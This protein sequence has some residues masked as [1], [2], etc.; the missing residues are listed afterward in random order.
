MDQ[1]ILRFPEQAD[2]SPEYQPYYQKS[3]AVVIGIDV[4]SGRHARLANA[5]NDAR[6]ITVLLRNYGFDP[7]VTFY[8]TGATRAAIMTYLDN[9]L[10]KQVG[11]DDRVV[12][13]FAGHGTTQTALD[14]RQ[15]GYLVPYDSHR[16]D[17]YIDL[18]EV[19]QLCSRLRAKHILLLLDCC[20]S[21]VAALAS[22]TPV[23]NPLAQETL[24][25]ETLSTDEFLRTAT[26]GRAWQ[27][28]TA[29]AA[30]EMVDDSSGQAGRST[31]TA[32]LIMGL[33]GAADYNRDG[34]ITA[35]DLAAYVRWQMAHANTQRGLTQTPFFAYLA[36]DTGGDF[37]FELSQKRTAIN[38][39]PP[40]GSATKTGGAPPLLISLLLLGTLVAFLFGFVALIFMYVP[41]RVEPLNPQSALTTPEMAL[42]TGITLLVVAAALGGTAYLLQRGL[43]GQRAWQ[44][45][46]VRQYKR[47]LQPLLTG[48]RR[49]RVDEQHRRYAQWL[50]QQS[51][52]RLT[53]KRHKAELLFYLYQQQLIVNQAVI[54]LRE[55]DLSGLDL[56]KRNLRAIDLAGTNLQKTNFSHATLVEANLRTANLTE[57]DLWSA[58]LRDAA[59][60][61]AILDRAN[62]TAATL[63]ARQLLTVKSQRQTIGIDGSLAA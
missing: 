54:S 26:R 36:D 42:I 19:R 3:W 41:I 9:E 6:A 5:C 8:D 2:L 35:T 39:Q 34:L 47:E 37:V 25:K 23:T 51:W 56:T 61:D 45:E 16:I 50:T 63:T 32:A 15:H 44:E 20:F 58:N 33:E 13:F 30:D 11:P 14:G 4:Y 52:N 60:D 1:T 62:L 49:A 53:D 55:L 57:A 24:S 12:C 18:E 17:E 7:V 29:G 46:T 22:P 48:L 31:F 10:T 59:L 38:H 40:S 27:V 43:F 28:L 21:G